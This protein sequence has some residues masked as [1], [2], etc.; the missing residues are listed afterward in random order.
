MRR[1]RIAAGGSPRTERALTIR[2]PTGATDKGVRVSPLTRLKIPMSAAIRGLPPA[3]ILGRRVRGFK[4]R[5]PN[6]IKIRN[7]C[8]FAVIRQ[9]RK[10]FAIC[11]FLLDLA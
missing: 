2:A 4:R 8:T 10:E 6:G 9:Q 3:A 5:K 7:I 1:P 11:E